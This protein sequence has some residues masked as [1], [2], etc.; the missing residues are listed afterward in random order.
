MNAQQSPLTL[1]DNESELIVN[2]DLDKTGALRRRNGYTAFASNGLFHTCGLFGT[3]NP[4]NKT[5]IAYRSTNDAPFATATERK[6]YYLSGGAWTVTDDTGQ[7]PFKP[8]TGATNEV[9]KTRFASLLNYIFRV[10]GGDIPVSFLITTPQTKTDINL[11]YVDNN[12]IAMTPS[13]IA[14]YADRMYINDTADGKRSRVYYST[15]AI[16]GS[17]ITW[18]ASAAAQ[19]YFDVNPDDGDFI[20]AFENNGNHLLI[21]KNYSMYR[22]IWGQIDADRIIGVGTTAQEGV[23]TDFERGI[24]FFANPEGV[25]AYDGNRPKLIS[26]KI[27]PYIDAVANADWKYVSGGVDRER[28]HLSVG[29]ITVNGRTIANAEFVYNIP[30]DAWTIWSLAEQPTCY[31]QISGTFPT[32]SLTF[33]TADGYDYYYSTATQDLDGG[34]TAKSISTEVITKEHLLVYPEKSTLENLD[35]LAIQ[36]GDTKVS[37]QVDRNLIGREGDFVSFKGGLNDRTNRFRIGKEMNTCRFRF[38]DNS[39]R[40]SII[41]GYNIEYT[42]KKEKTK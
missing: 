32:Q 12:T 28:Y 7:E 3:M 21:F 14:V 31:A 37:Y 5:P 17:E 13:L 39:V 16:P 34:T 2:Y 4:N 27:Q 40:D 11:A 6:T 9:F 30:L 8:T 35:V 25:Y 20:T 23:A 38:A 24:T 15:E 33:G 36:G 10:N 42:P 1:K 22:W 29:D 18:G 19:Q 26:K 41:E